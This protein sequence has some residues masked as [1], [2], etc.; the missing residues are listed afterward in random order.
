ML[1]ELPTE[2]ATSSG[3]GFLVSYDDDDG[4]Y[5]GTSCL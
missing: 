2:L 1:F 5:V 3:I 4:A